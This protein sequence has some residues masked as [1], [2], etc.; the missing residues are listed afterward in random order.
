M[1][2]EYAD[3]LF[4]PFSEAEFPRQ[5]EPLRLQQLLSRWPATPIPSSPPELNVAHQLWTDRD[6]PLFTLATPHE[7]AVLLCNRIIRA[8]AVSWPSTTPS[9]LRYTTY[10]DTIGCDLPAFASEM[11]AFGALVYR[12]EV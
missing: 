10:W 11:L 9:E 3:R 5:L 7:P 6:H 1:S 4:A 2:V 12:Y 8:L